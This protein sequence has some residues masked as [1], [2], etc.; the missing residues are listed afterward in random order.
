MS[1]TTRLS[2]LVFA[3]VVAGLLWILLPAATQSR[4]IF[5]CLMVLQAAVIAIVAYLVGRKIDGD[6]RWIREYQPSSDASAASAGLADGDPASIRNKIFELDRMLQ[7]TR[8]KYDHQLLAIRKSLDTASNSILRHRLAGD[9]ANL[10]ESTHILAGELMDSHLAL[11][12]KLDFQLAVASAMPGYILI[13]D[14]TGRIR[15]CNRQ[16]ADLFGLTNKIEID[17][18]LKKFVRFKDVADGELAGYLRSASSTAGT[19]QVFGNRKF[20][21]RF[22]FVRFQRNGEQLVL[23]LMTDRTEELRTLAVQNQHVK[24]ATAQVLIRENLISELPL[25]ESLTAKT[26]LVVNDIKQRAEKQTILGRLSHCDQD[27]NHLSVRLRLW[28]WLYRTE[29]ATPPEPVLS[30]ISGEELMRDAMKSLSGIFAARKL[31]PKVVNKGGWVCVDRDMISVGIM[32]LMAYAAEVSTSNTFE[33]RIEKMPATAD[34]PEGWIS[35]AILGEWKEESWPTSTVGHA[36]DSLII[37]RDET[38]IRA[39]GAIGIVVAI[40][41]AQLLKGQCRRAETPDGRRCLQIVIPT[42][43]PTVSPAE[44]NVVGDVGP[45]EELVMGWKLGSAV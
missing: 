23:L 44:L 40:R 28:E 25:V 10:P 33:A 34:L 8:T 39:D 31:T 7:N 1:I 14:E 43:L 38:D 15:S 19:G 22:Q 29:W 35:F 24:Q 27:L 37:G 9:P 45:R 11:S 12:D 42:K 2:F 32:G 20:E 21:I 3:P 4:E 16:A 6:H 17:A 26:R 41:A 5:I 18:N 13:A 30:E 36:I